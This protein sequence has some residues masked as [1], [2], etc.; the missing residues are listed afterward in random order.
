MELKD[1]KA[2]VLFD[3]LNVATK[4]SE[5]AS[6]HRYGE[7]RYTTDTYRLGCDN[8]TAEIP[9]PVFDEAMNLTIEHYRTQLR[10][11]GVEA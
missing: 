5:H 2:A 3:K 4:L 11:L 10:A 1:I 9:K 7:D 8:I 6:R